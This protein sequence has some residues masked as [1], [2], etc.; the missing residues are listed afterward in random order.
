MPSNFNCRRLAKDVTVLG[1]TLA[2]SILLGPNALANPNN[3]SKSTAGWTP[4][5]VAQADGEQPQAG[6]DQG[7]GGGDM[8]RLR[9]RQFQEGQGGPMQGSDADGIRRRMREKMRQRFGEGGEPGM[10]PNAPGDGSQPGP[11]DEG[12]PRMPGDGELP[13]FRQN[14]F[15]GAGQGQGFGVGAGQ[16]FRRRGGQGGEGAGPD[17]EGGFKKRGFRRMDGGPDGTGG[18][19]RGGGMRERKMFR[20]GGQLF[21][22][23]PLDLSSLNLTEAQK[24]R[25]KEIRQQSSPRSRELMKSIQASR[26]SLKDMMFDPNMTDAQIRAK[27]AELRKLQDQSEDLTLND[28]LTIRSVLSKEQKAKLPQIKPGA[29]GPG[30]PGPDGPRFAGP[31]GGPDGPGPRGA[32][33]PPGGADGEPMEVSDGPNQRRR[34]EGF[35]GNNQD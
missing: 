5:L 4:Y 15:G 1:F 33:S 2:V 29:G 31:P 17:G 6:P 19:P 9:R 24:T 35:R 7:G 26:S 22:R 8:R 20:G 27:R 11:A 3:L 25:I 14:R 32:G 21:G 16:G 18:G 23:G 34:L 13:R 10:P 12:G 30:G 28:F